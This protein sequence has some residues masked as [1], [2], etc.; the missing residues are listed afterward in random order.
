MGKIFHRNL[1]PRSFSFKK[2]KS[3]SDKWLRA[4]K[5]DQNL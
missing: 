4:L 1:T 3:I 2:F 5:L